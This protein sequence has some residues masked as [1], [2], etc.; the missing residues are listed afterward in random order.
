[1]SNKVNFDNT[2]IAFSL[3]SDFELKQAKYLFSAIGIG[4]LTAIAKPATNFLFKVRF[5]IGPILKKTVFKQFC[6]G[7]TIEECRPLI[8]TLYKQ[9]G[10]CSILDYSVEYK[11]SEE[12]FNATVKIVLDALE[13]ARTSEATPFL[14]F[15]ATALGRFKLFQ[16]VSAGLELNNQE[17]EEWHRVKDRFDLIC[18]SCARSKNVKLMIDAEESWIQGSIDAIAEEMMG[19]Y[20]Q[21]RPVVFNTVQLYRWDRLAYLKHMLAFGKANNCQ[22]GVKLVR[23]AYMEKE[24]QRALEM[25]YKSPICNSKAESDANFNNGLRFCLENLNVFQIFLGTHN[26][27]SSLLLA[28]LMA[29]HNFN[30]SDQRF[31]FGQLYGMGDHISFNLSKEKYNTAKY[32]PFGPVKEVMPYLFRRAEENSSVGLQ[33]SRE[34]QLIEKELQRRT[35]KIF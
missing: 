25:D 1:M 35:Q 14:V 24:R 4:W 21:T 9:K 16:K 11:E 23:G 2:Q 18:K 3:K 32:L 8:N 28:N 31:W 7:E 17:Q 33:T 22:V 34:L 13:F 26:E 19:M 10:V 27:E 30:N 6:G 29:K 12:Q 15:K 5:P 20:N